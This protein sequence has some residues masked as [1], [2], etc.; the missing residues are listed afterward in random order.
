MNISKYGLLLNG[1]FVDYPSYFKS[2][3]IS[4][5]NDNDKGWNGIALD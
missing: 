2:I 4:C 5:I 1:I 3:K